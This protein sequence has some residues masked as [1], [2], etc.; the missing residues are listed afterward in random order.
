MSRA[1]TLQTAALFL[2][3]G[4]IY[5]PLTPTKIGPRALL[6][7]VHP[8]AQIYLLGVLSGVT[9]CSKLNHLML[10]LQ[11]L[12]LRVQVLV[13]GSGTFLQGTN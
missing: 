6:G 5:G 9:Y 11:G 1:L 3:P 8:S 4:T 13:W 2:I 10:R 12:V 7:E